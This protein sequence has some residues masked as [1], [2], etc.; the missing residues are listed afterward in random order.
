MQGQPR[1]ATAAMKVYKNRGKVNFDASSTCFFA[2][3][4]NLV[5]ENILSLL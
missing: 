3:L 1:F 4:L 2:V 5:R